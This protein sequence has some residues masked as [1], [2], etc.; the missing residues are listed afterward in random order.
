MTKYDF[1]IPKYRNDKRQKIEIA[2]NQNPNIT[3]IIENKKKKIK[4]IK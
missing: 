1:K 4:K 2:K 3:A